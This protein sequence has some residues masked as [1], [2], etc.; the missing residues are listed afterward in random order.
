[1]AKKFTEECHARDFT[2][3]T[4][5]E[6]DEPFPKTVLFRGGC[7]KRQ[8]GGSRFKRRIKAIAYFRDG[9]IFLRH[10]LFD[11]YKKEPY[12]NEDRKLIASNKIATHDLAPEMKAKEIADEIITAVKRENIISYWLILPIWT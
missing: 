10:F 2:Y 11:G 6:Y 9:K 1:M 5:M 8:F 3:I 4:M 12:P 7:H